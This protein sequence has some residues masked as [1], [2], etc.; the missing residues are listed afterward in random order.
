MADV[1]FSFGQILLKC[2]DVCLQ[3]KH[4]IRSAGARQEQEEVYSCIIPKLALTGTRALG[5]F[6]TVCTEEDVWT[7]GQIT[8]VVVW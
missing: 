4:V 7:Q 6:D 1:L 3:T 8:L 5:D 2:E